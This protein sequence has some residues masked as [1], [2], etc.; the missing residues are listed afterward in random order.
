MKHLLI[1]KLYKILPVKVRWLISYLLTEKYLVGTTA[2][3]VK[4]KQVLLVKNSY[5]YNW[6]FPGG[7][8][9]KNENIFAS[10]QREMKEEL[11]ITISPEKIIGV[12]SDPERRHVDILILAHLTEEKVAID[13]QEIEQAEFFDLYDLPV[14]LIKAQKPY[15]ELLKKELD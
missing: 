4:E 13:H 10:I 1:Y 3:L 9:K 7:F 6:S 8:L 14:Q 15:I 11:G 5:N 12:I 2:F